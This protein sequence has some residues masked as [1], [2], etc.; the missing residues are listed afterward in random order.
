MISIPV[1]IGEVIDK[2]T[3]LEIKLEK[4]IDEQPKQNIKK[5]LDLLLLVCENA[6]LTSNLTNRLRKINRLLWNVEDEIRKKE[7]S[8]LFDE[9]FIKLARA[10]Y[11]LNDKRYEIK[12][13]INLL[14]N[15][16]IIEEKIYD[17]G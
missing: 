15:S 6:L 5:E 3:I 9:Q 16:T 13:E 7:L 4:V 11:R 17:N 2:I 1:S 14:N 12:K 8:K 10:V